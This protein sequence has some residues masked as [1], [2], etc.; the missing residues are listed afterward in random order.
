[1]T[2]MEFHPKIPFYKTALFEYTLLEDLLNMHIF[3]KPQLL[4]AITGTQLQAGQ[5]NRKVWEKKIVMQNLMIDVKVSLLC[6]F[7][8]TIIIFAATNHFVEVSFHD[9]FSLLCR[10]ECTPRTKL[11]KTFLPS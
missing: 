5:A 7:V 10:I 6:T 11:L 8:S 3:S 2:H 9:S 1:M 4:L